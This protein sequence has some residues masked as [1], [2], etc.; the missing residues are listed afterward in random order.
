MQCVYIILGC[1]TCKFKCLKSVASAPTGE[2]RF[3]FQ[4]ILG[5]CTWSGA[6]V[7]GKLGIYLLILKALGILDKCRFLMFCMFWQ[8]DIHNLYII[9]LNTKIVVIYLVGDKN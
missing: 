4:C 9:E 6:N 7:V 1:L 3:L 5:V 2:T 8:K